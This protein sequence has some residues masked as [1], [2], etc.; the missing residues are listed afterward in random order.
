MSKAELRQQLEARD[1]E[2]QTKDRLMQPGNPVPGFLSVSFNDTTQLITDVGLRGA[3]YLLDFWG[4]WCGPCVRE[5]PDLEKVYDRYE[6]A[7]FEIVSIAF[8]DDPEDIE[9]FRKDRYSMPWLHTRVGRTEDN[10]VR[11]KFELRAFPKP[12][13]VNENGII[14]AI[15]DELRDGNVHQ[16]VERL[17]GTED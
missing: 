6:D 17:L 13:L 1:S 4:T 14:V 8:L 3:P 11:E 15:D 5:I 16:E 2:L 7:G 10:A 12:I 9:Q